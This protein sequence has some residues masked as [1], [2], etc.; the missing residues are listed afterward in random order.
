MGIKVGDRVKV[1][2]GYGSSRAD[3]GEVVKVGRVW[4]TIKTQT[5]GQKARFR[6]DDQT[7]GSSHSSKARFYTPEQWA[8][9]EARRE[10][11]LFLRGQGV[12]IR[13]GGEWFGREVELAELIKAVGK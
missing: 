11:L 7:D 6:L 12:E 5:W 9:R 3:D 4:I 1:I 2:T 8:D 13:L 10:A